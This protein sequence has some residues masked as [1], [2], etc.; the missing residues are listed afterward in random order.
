MAQVFISYSRKDLSFVDKLAADLKNAGVDVWYDVSGIGGGSRWRSEIENA[1]RNSQYVIVVLSPD[2]ITSEW[3]EREFLF[4]SNLKRKIIP[5]MYRSCELPL[6]YLDLNYI[7]VQGENYQREFP[8]L[9]KALVVDVT[10]LTLPATRVKGLRPA[11]KNI[12][13]V[14]G[15]LVILIAAFWVI[16]YTGIL[17]SLPFELTPTSTEL[18]MEDYSLPS[19]INSGGAEM[20]LI[21]AENFTMGVNVENALKECKKH[22]SDC[23][24]RWFEDE[25]PS[26]VIYMEAFYIDRYEITNALYRV[27][28]QAGECDPPTQVSSSSRTSYYHDPQF[29]NYPVIYVNW[30]MADTYCRWRGASLPSEAQWEKAAR[31]PGGWTYPWGDQFDSSR[32]NFCDINCASSGSNRDYDD[33]YKDTAPV[34]SY[35]EG[36]SLYVVYNMSG[37]VWE[38]VDN[39]YAVY[40]GGNP[41]GSSYFEPLETYRVIRG[42]S[43]DS[44]IDLLRAANRDPKKPFSAENNVGFRCAMKATP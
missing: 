5:L 15:V 35:Y 7:D 25:S 28:E 41:T 43:W 40:P 22:R 2:A 39:W 19:T 24:E 1:L 38:W 34:D 36:T 20:S 3:V 23:Q 29:D 6:N 27:C 21:P 44:T 14:V 18:P 26:R 16:S 9:L 4:A 11:L 12:A 10:K 30:D 8:D 37:N 13:M 31:G 33:G 32:V 42:G 17:S